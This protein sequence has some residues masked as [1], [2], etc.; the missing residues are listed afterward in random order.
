ML[1]IILKYCVVV[2]LLLQLIDVNNLKAQKNNKTEQELIAKAYALYK[3]KDYVRALPLYSQ[4]LSLYPKNP[5][6]SYRFGV[7][8]LFGDR[9]DLYKPLQYI[10]YGAEK[11]IDDPQIYYYLGLAYHLNYR[12]PEAIREY[13]KYKNLNKNDKYAVTQANYSILMCNNGINLLKKVKDLYVISKNEI[14]IKDFYRSY[15]ISNF[16]GKFLAKPEFLKSRLDK[17]YKNNSIIFLSDNNSII[18]FSSYGEKNK[19]GKDIYRSQKLPNGKWSKPERLSDVINTPYDED[20]PFLLPDG[21]TLYFCSKGHNSMGG[22][23]IFKSTWDT[24]TQ[25]WSTPENLDFA[26]NTPSDDILFVT[27]TSQLY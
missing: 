4:L 23:D 11:N 13:E 20:Y 2:L 9:R 25:E 6:Y 7:C 27:D 17:K 10:N 8:L 22:Y 12:F 24:I 21:K 5:Y 1:K 19:T 15:D 26:I 16:G 18:Y 14:S 3:N